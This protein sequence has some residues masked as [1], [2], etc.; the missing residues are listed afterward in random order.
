MR[1]S[2]T[3]LA[4]LVL[5][6]PI[7]A[8]ASE[9]GDV[10]LGVWATEPDPVDGNAHI[11]LYKE[12]DGYSGKVVWLE[13]PQY[14]ADEGDGLAGKDKVD[15]ENP[16]PDLRSRPIMGLNLLEGFEYVGKKQWKNGTIYDPDNGKTYKCKMKLTKDGVLKIRGFIGVSLIGRTT[17]WT[18]VSSDE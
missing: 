3:L 6:L 17:E 4:V 16:D 2:G 15:R 18:R 1:T 7:S 8:L 14:P 5:A 10:I 9:D 13:Q 12:G 11:E